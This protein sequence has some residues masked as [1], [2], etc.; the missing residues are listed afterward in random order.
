MA[1]RGFA[2]G[3]RFSRPR[4]TEPP[5]R[6]QLGRIQAETLV[7]VGSVDMDIIHVI[8]DGVMQ[9]LPHA[10][11]VVV[12]NTAHMVNMEEPETFNALVTEF[13]TAEE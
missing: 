7:I 10:H 12:E 5:A 4:G 2:L 3:A 6:Q 11:K 8:C 9:E 13:L 1:T